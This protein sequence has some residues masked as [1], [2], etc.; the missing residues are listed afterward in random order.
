MVNKKIKKEYY[1]L[2]IVL[3]IVI[4]LVA[5]FYVSAYGKF[6]SEPVGLPSCIALSGYLCQNATYNYTNGNIL[7]WLGQDTKQT[8]YSANFVFVPQGT[9]TN[10]SGLPMISFSSS[11]AN[12]L[13][14][15]L[16]LSVNKVVN[17]YLPDTGP[18]NPGHTTV[19]TIWVQYTT[20]P[21]S[22]QTSYTEI[23]ELK[24]NA[25]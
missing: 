20:Q 17:V 23:A 19:G 8:W 1:I 2:F 12:T 14:N 6:N 4:I 11:P 16:G 22:N 25:S 18:V 21:R 13:Y 5:Y 9:T 7:V 15:S 10:T 24:L 3:I